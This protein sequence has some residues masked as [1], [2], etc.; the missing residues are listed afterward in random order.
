[1]RSSG[2][3]GLLRTL[4]WKRSLV[5]NCNFIEEMTHAVATQHRFEQVSVMG[6][7]EK[8]ITLM[9]ET[10]LRSGNRFN[11]RPQAFSSHQLLGRGGLRLV[12]FGRER[13]ELCMLWRQR[14]P[15]SGIGEREPTDGGISVS[16][17]Y[18]RLNSLDVYC[19][20]TYD[21]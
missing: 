9:I 15:F 18:S 12:L 21:I 10:I 11:P 20:S 4:S 14:Y 16:V 2:S 1:M 6:M 8:L 19:C 3:C 13:A 5:G 7:E 17:I